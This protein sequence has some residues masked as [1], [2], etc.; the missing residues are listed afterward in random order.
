MT[1]G[2]SAN[3]YT[4]GTLVT[5]GTL[6]F[7]STGNL[8][9]GSNLTVGTGTTTNFSV[10]NGAP[11]VGDLSGAGI[12][13][14]G[15]NTLTAGTTNSTT[16][17]GVI[18]GAGGFTKQNTGT[19]TFSN[20]N[21]YSGTTTINGG[22]F[23]LTGAG[24]LN[25][26][27]A[28]SPVS[29][30]S[31]TSVFDISTDTVSGGPTIGDLSG[32][33]NSSVTLGANNLNV[34]TS[35]TNTFAGVISGTSN[36]ASLTVTGS[37]KTI[38]TGIN[39]YTGGTIVN[40]TVALSAGGTL[41]STGA[42]TLNS[43][44]TFDISASTG[45]PVIG[46]L[47]GASGSIVTLG[48][49]TLTAGTTN[50]TT[51][52]GVMSGTGGFTKQ[53]TGTISFS[54]VNAYTGTTTINGGELALT[55]AGNL[56]GGATPSPV[57]VNSSTSIFD[58]TD[59]AAVGGATIGDLSSVAS[60]Q[61]SLG[62]NTL[63]IQTSSTNTVA[64]TISGSTGAALVIGGTGET[65]LTGSVGSG[66]G[67]TLNNSATFALSGASA[68]F[69]GPL[70][71]NGTSAFDVSAYTGGSASITDLNGV[72]GTFV[73]LGNVPLLITPTATD[74][75]AGAISGTGGTLNIFGSNKLILTGTN[76]YAG[77]TNLNGSSTLALSAGGTLATTAPVSLSGTST[78][79]I[80]GS[81]VVGGVVIGDLTG[82]SG[83]SVT[84]GT[85]TLTFGTATTPVTFAGNISGSGGITK[86]GT[87][88]AI[89]SGTNSFAG[90]TINVGTLQINASTAFPS[91]A[92]ANISA[93]GAK[94]DFSNSSSAQTIGDLSGVSG[95]LLTM[96]ANALTFG[97]ATATTTFAGNISST[98]TG[99][100]TK[101]GSGIAIF[102]GTNTFTGANISAGT[103]QINASTAF[104][105]TASANISASGTTLDFSNSSSA[106][107]IGDLSGVSGAL[108][109]MGAN[110]LTFGTATTSTTFAGNLPAQLGSPSKAA[111]SLSFLEQTL[112]LA[113]ILTQVRCRSTQARLSLLLAA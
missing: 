3:N 75:Y 90:A 50:S 2:S 55:G 43:G 76:S 104:P 80:S 11:T 46:D 108:L 47:T 42:V 39:T 81:S 65:L 9:S 96:G 66:I 71:L 28:P 94:L 109:T 105:S 101:Q 25:G 37:G 92:N 23:S 26:G 44:S 93:S 56:N 64:G 38:L 85:N 52:A 79:D 73:R 49:N 13:T 58:I 91:T 70:D 62:A 31:S 21:G 15:A 14:L 68:A 113:Q 84:L 95:S 112:S 97:T 35:S 16:F 4:G 51:F 107:T 34:Q 74:T 100:I 5:N 48:A 41:A 111:A 67:A 88:T 6:N 12:I 86:Q 53:N 22:E 24:N 72:S 8:P 78:F 17:S 60:S 45:S 102:S 59:S 83:T 18:N 103:L 63:N 20:Q 87:G 61:V 98:A 54:N 7:L 77:G 110:A 29:V 89:L 69:S 40:S 19:I 33:A 32:V 36:T 57:S 30:N 99:G 106:Q 27:T 82:V 10:Y 1:L